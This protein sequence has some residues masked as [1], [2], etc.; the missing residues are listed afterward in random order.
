M[1]TAQPGG[2]PKRCGVKV[3]MYQTGSGYQGIGVG[4]PYFMAGFI[5]FYSSDLIVWTVTQIFVDLKMS[6]ISL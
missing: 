6:S 3:S 5:T 4:T 2:Q 1:E